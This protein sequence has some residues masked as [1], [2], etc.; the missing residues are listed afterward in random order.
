MLRPA[1]TPILKEAATSAMTPDQQ[2]ATKQDLGELK[3]ELLA[4]FHEALRDTEEHLIERMRDMQTETVR[5]F[6]DFQR[7]NET[8][9]STQEKNAGALGERVASLE[10]RLLEIERK[11]LLNP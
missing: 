7:Q 5:V 11:L 10:H 6:M 9:Q 8:R 3:A 4:A 1:E 2:P